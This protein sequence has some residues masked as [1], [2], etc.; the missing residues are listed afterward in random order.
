MD[1]HLTI[2]ALYEQEIKSRSPAERLKLVALIAQ[3]L[4]AASSEDEQRPYS[5]LDLEGLGAEIW[6]GI[7]AQA[8][9]DSLR[10]EWDQWP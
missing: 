3:D 4:A 2:D 7:D 8:Y 6:Q 10:R 5:L 9:V 1:H